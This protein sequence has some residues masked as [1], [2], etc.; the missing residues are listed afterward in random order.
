MTMSAGEVTLNGEILQIIETELWPGAT[1][2]EFTVT[3]TDLRDA[4][5]E[6]TLDDA[7]V[8]LPPAAG[9]VTAVLHPSAAGPVRT[10]RLRTTVGPVQF[11]ERGPRYRSTSDGPTPTLGL[12]RRTLNQTHIPRP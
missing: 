1:G 6:V 9:P 11:R 2:T 5:L 7:V 10:M 4:A 8:A 3:V 12:E